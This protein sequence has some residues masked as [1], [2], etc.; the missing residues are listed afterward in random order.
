MLTQLIPYDDYW[1]GS[2][3]SSVSFTLIVEEAGI[4]EITVSLICGQIG[5]RGQHDEQQI[6]ATVGLQVAVVGSLNIF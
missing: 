4:E 6:V 2:G 5:E 3:T 1:F